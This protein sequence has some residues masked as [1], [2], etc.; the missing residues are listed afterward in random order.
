L[1]GFRMKS[2]WLAFLA[3]NLVTQGILNI[4]LSSGGSLLPGYLIF[5]LLIGE[6]LVFMAELIT[7]PLIVKEH[8]AFRITACVFCA[9]VISLIAG[10]YI[11]TVLPV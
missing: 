5:S 6:V 1:F 3:I 11:I 2:S 8:T 7:F 9:N 4:W 10:G